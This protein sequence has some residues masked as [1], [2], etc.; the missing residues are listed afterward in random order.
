MWRVYWDCVNCVWFLDSWSFVI[1]FDDIIV[2]FWDCRNFKSKVFSLEGYIN[3]VKSIE[4]YRF[5]GLIVMLVF[6][7]MVWI[8]DI[9]RYV[10]DGIV[11]GRVVL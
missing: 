11:Y 4:Y 2:V 5:F 8:W 7:D 3:W 9:N 1:C 6:D 10:N